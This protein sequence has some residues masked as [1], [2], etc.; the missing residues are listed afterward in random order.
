V[1]VELTV[2]RR[3]LRDAVRALLAKHSPAAAVRVALES[4]DGYDHELWARLCTEI[5]VAGLAIPERYG[6]LGAGPLETH[7][8]L[9]ELGRALTPSPMLGCAV[10][11]VQALVNSGGEAACRRLLPAIAA[12]DHIAAVAWTRP[13]GRWDPEE[14]ALLATGADATGTC[15]LSGEAHYVL[16]GHL[17]DTLLVGARGLTGVGLYEVDARSTGVTRR[18]VGTMDL[19]RRLAVV[20]LDGVTGHRLGT[21]NP[22]ASIRDIACVA[23]SAEQVGATDRALE[24]T[25]EYARTRVQFGRPIGAF[26]ALQHRLA[27]LH[28]LAASAR[29][30]SYAAATA[31]STGAPDAGR[32]AA[33]AKVTCSEAFERVAG[34]MIQIHGGIGITWEH[35]AHLYFKHAHS[36]AHLFGHPREHVRRLAA[37][38]LDGAGA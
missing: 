19:T 32:L 26:Q 29:S 2:E 13:T 35:D 8:V 37:D 1:I 31:I 23:L 16:D 10:L 38:V 17:A 5:G 27:D 12:G 28:V 34:E 25:V 15:R 21:G 22:L 33:V 14:V 6:G 11:A 7:I 36:T 18:A 20:V 3:A 4:A 30:A 24:L 9:D